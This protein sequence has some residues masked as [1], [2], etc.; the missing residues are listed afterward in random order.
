MKLYSLII[1]LFLYISSYS[2]VSK[3]I[4]S[5]EY[6]TITPA[7]FCNIFNDSI[8]LRL[9]FPF[10]KDSESLT[11]QKLLQIALAWNT[12][13]VNYELLKLK[14]VD[15]C[16]MKSSPNKRELWGN[17]MNSIDDFWSNDILFFNNG[18]LC[19]NQEDKNSIFPYYR[20]RSNKPNASYFNP[21]L[22][23]TLRKNNGIQIDSLIELCKKDITINDFFIDLNPPEISYFIIMDSDK[24][25]KYT[26]NDN[27]I[28]DG[29]KKFINQLKAKQFIEI[30]IIINYPNQENFLISEK[31]GPLVYQIIE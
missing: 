3:G 8:L 19:L 23:S 6:D 1:A 29:Q 13:I 17:F 16:E 20:I 18:M 11:Y 9:T 7:E 27:K 15:L 21:M 2:Q 14:E 4:D 26:S 12:P 25:I 5:L 24:K 10:F 30:L 28:S 31:I 22:I